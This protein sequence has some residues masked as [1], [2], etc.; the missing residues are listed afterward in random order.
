MATDTSLYIVVCPSYDSQDGRARSSLCHFP[1]MTHQ[2]RT[3]HKINTSTMVRVRAYKSVRCS[4]WIPVA[5]MTGVGITSRPNEPFP[6]MSWCC[7]S[8]AAMFGIVWCWAKE[9]STHCFVSPQTNTLEFAALPWIFT[10][11]FVTF[12]LSVSGSLVYPVLF[13]FQYHFLLFH[14]FD[15]LYCICGETR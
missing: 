7:G 4:I 14:P 2:T 1:F 6:Y 15:Y 10:L 12:V 8:L 9:R 3:K 5:S 11:F 13:C